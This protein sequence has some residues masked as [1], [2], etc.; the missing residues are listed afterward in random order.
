M[1]K[2]R[3]P[4]RRAKLEELRQILLFTIDVFASA[5]D[6]PDADKFRDVVESVF[7]KEDLRAMRLLER[8]INMMGDLVLD[9]HQRDGLQAALAQR[10]GTPLSGDLAVGERLALSALR[11]GRIVSERERQRL[12]DYVSVL[13]RSGENL[14]Q[15]KLLRELLGSH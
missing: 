10:F 15:L 3:T 5:Q 2:P 14:E 4:A 11:R 1:K 7:R 9:L 8:E 12:E 13:E 6:F